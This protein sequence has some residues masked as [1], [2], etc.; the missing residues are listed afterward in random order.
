MINDHLPFLCLEFEN[1]QKDLCRSYLVEKK[2]LELKAIYAFTKYFTGIEHVYSYSENTIR[3][4]ILS[5][6]MFVN[7]QTSYYTAVLEQIT[8]IFIWLHNESLFCFVFSSI[9]PIISAIYADQ[10]SKMMLI[11]LRPSMLFRMSKY[12]SIIFLVIGSFYLA[13]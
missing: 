12:S 6:P 2:M 11:C 13:F 3:R 7:F 8:L 4:G 5:L 1:C 9:Q 10:E